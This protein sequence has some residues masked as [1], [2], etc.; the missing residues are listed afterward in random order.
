ML[1][2]NIIGL[3]LHN[4]TWHVYLKVTLFAGTFFGNFGIIII[5]HVLNFA[6]F[7]CE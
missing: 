3:V 6:I 4:H 2:N 7:T 5:L 1:N